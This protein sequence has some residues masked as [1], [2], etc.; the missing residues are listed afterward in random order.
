M[1]IDRSI[2]SR[3]WWPGTVGQSSREETEK[4]MEWA[5][6]QGKD[7]FRLRT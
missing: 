4:V 3:G 6:V 7:L 5:Q 2:A 1:R